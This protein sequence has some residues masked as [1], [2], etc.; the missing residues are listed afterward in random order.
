[1]SN[2]KLNHPGL[3]I[4][5]RVLFALMTLAVMTYIFMLSA[6]TAEQSSQT[7]AG[8][9]EKAVDTFVSSYKEM[10]VEEKEQLVSSLQDIVRKAAHFTIF[11]A[12]GFFTSCFA[13][14]YK[15]KLLKKLLICQAFCSL[16][17]TSDEYHQTFSEGRSF[18]L[19]DIVMDSFGS[20]CGILFVFLIIFLYVKISEKRRR[21]REKT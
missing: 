5:F 4:L 7:S 13:A 15:G 19:S 21:Q 6:E 17:A 12:L 1:M 16:Y 18:Q 3:K 10:P 11:A 9:I 14:T 2:V 20:L 8:L